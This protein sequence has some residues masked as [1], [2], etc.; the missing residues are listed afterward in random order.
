MHHSKHPPI[1][2]PCAPVNG[3]KSAAGPNRNCPYNRKLMAAKAAGCCSTCGKLPRE[4]VDYRTFL[5]KFT[6]RAEVLHLSDEEFDP[7]LY[8]YG[9]HTYGCLPLIE[10]LEFRDEKRLSSFSYCAGYIGL[11]QSIAFHALFQHTCQLLL[12]NGT[13]FRRFHLHILQCDAAVTGDTV[14]AH[15]GRV[16]AKAFFHPPARR[17]RHGFSPVFTSIKEL[18]KNDPTFRPQGLLYFTDGKG[19]FPKNRPPYPTAFV[20]LREEDDPPMVPPWAI[21]ATWRQHELIEQ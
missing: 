12:Q 21:A 4:K 3:N 11:M 17:G 20:F 2:I 14:I 6:H 7:I 18:M 5:Q 10:P 1:T 15:P 16:A 8:T 19:R 13:L 9:L